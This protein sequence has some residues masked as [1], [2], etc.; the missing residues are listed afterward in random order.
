MKQKLFLF[1]AVRTA[2]YAGKYNNLIFITARSKRTTDINDSYPTRGWWIRPS[3]KRVSPIR[4]CRLHHSTEKEFLSPEYRFMKRRENP[5]RFPKMQKKTN[6]YR[7]VAAFLSAYRPSRGYSVS[8]GN[9]YQ[10][11]YISEDVTYVYIS[12]CL[13]KRVISRVHR[14]AILSILLIVSRATSE[15]RKRGNES[16]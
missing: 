13:W 5:N 4:A 16:N 12:S 11:R 7:E 9:Q 15:E 3:V 6:L 8:S 1:H 2:V 10:T 14:D